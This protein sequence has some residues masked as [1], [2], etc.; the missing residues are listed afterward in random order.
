ML[1]G[2]QAATVASEAQEDEIVK[3]QGIWVAQLSV[4]PFAAGA[5]GMLVSLQTM[6]ACLLLLLRISGQTDPSRRGKV[7]CMPVQ[8]CL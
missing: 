3:S 5:L 6:L 1:Y 2:E 7:S 8:S 4:I